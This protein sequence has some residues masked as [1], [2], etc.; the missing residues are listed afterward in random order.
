MMKNIQQNNLCPVQEAFTK[1]VRSWL[2]SLETTIPEVSSVHDS[3]CGLLQPA[4]ADQ[5]RIGW[6]LA[7]QEYLSKH[8]GLA[9]SANCHLEENNDK[10]EVWAQKTV[11]QLWAFTHEMWEH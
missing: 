3:Q 6:H 8:W 1:C 2:K 10:G 4:I 7:M 11:L 9:V 5:T